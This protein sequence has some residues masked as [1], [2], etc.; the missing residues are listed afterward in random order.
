MGYEYYELIS[1]LPSNGLRTI[2][3]LVTFG[4]DLTQMTVLAGHVRMAAALL[5]V[6]LRGYV[7]RYHRTF[8]DSRFSVCV[9]LTLSTE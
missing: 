8:L 2:V 6:F 3:S 7:K 9:A 1:S 5:L 4:G